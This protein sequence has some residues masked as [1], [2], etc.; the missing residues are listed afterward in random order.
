MQEIFL[1]TKERMKKT[2]DLL[3]KKYLEIRAGRANPSILDRI[4]VDYYGTQ[5]PIS[6]IASVSI[7]EA[8]VLVIQPWDQSLLNPVERAIQQ[9]DIGINPQNDGTVI[10]LIFPELNEDMRKS[11]AKDI[12]NMSEESKVSIR[13]IRRDAIDALK[14]KKKNSEITEDELKSG[15]KQIQNITDS[16]IGEIDKMCENKKSEI[17]TI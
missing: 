6:Q 4:N 15:E 11:I 2:I 13:S 9:S 8:R 16:S 14:N 7:S 17:M 10:R 12:S 5:T 1:N 3:N